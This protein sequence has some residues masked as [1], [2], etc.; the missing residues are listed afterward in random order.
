[1]ILARSRSSRRASPV[2]KVS[3]LLSMSSARASGLVISIWKARARRRT[4]ASKSTFAAV[5]SSIPLDVANRALHPPRRQKIA[6]LDNRRAV[7]VPGGDPRN[8]RS[9]VDGSIIGALSRREPLG[10]ALPQRQIFVPQ[11]HCALTS[12]EG[13]AIH[14]VRPLHERGS[15]TRAVVPFR[16]PP[17]PPPPPPP[18]PPPPPP[19]PPPPFPPPPPGARR[20]AA[21]ELG[22]D[23]C[24]S[25]RFRRFAS[26]AG[27]MRSA[28]APLLLRSAAG[29][30]SVGAGGRRDTMPGLPTRPLVPAL[31]PGIFPLP[32]LLRGRGASLS[33]GSRLRPRVS[34]NGIGSWPFPQAAARL[35]PDLNL[36]ALNLCLRTVGVLTLKCIDAPAGSLASRSLVV[37]LV[38]IP[39]RWGGTGAQFR[40][41]FVMLM[42]DTVPRSATRGG[43]DGVDAGLP[44]RIAARGCRLQPVR[45]GR[46]LTGV[47]E[48]PDPYTTRTL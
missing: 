29:E 34:R 19:P 31:R 32:R 28:R 20:P 33:E 4:G 41:E 24:F 43:P 35:Q 11:R 40:R 30:V 47:T 25:R 15:N 26:I 6:L 7:L 38:A 9:P 3:P 46:D 14:A 48:R 8:R 42:P 22:D 27:V 45:H 5:R 16:P 12:R 44:R 10:R 17:P 2:E 36:T 37:P 39:E 13:S 21:S 18:L 23:C 1:M